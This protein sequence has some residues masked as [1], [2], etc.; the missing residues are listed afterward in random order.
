MPS[1]PPP[2][3]NGYDEAGEDE[4]EALLDRKVEAAIDPG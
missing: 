1:T 2:L 4:L 3:W